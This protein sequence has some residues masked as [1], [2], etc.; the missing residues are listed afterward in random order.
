MGDKSMVR[1]MPTEEYFALVRQALATDGKAYVRVTGNSMRP[2]LRHLKDGV[3]I[4]PPDHLRAGDIVLFD[5]GNGR[6]ALHRVIRLDENG[7]SMAGDNQSILET[8]LP[9]AGIVGI[10]DVID[11]GGRKLSRDGF[12]FKNYA[13]LLTSCAMPRIYIR[14]DL[15]KLLRLFG[16]RPISKGK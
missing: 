7:F 1:L 2:L 10:V 14:R 8:G 12:I 9:Y 15:G 4:V 13:R 11:R 16:R 5:R 3:V 6:F